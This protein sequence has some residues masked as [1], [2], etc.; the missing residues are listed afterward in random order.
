[1]P[2]TPHHDEQLPAADTRPGT[3][4]LG[5]L[6]FSLRGLLKLTTGVA[7]FFSL[8]A[9]SG[10]SFGTFLLGLYVYCVWLLP[11]TIWVAMKCWPRA[12][13]KWRKW[14]GVT[15]GAALVIPPVVAQLTLEGRAM[16]AVSGLLGLL[17]IWGIEVPVLIFFVHILPSG[18]RALRWHGDLWRFEDD[19]PLKNADDADR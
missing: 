8:V 19:G 1:M 7:V 4:S 6:Q 14:V 5:P 12:H 3:G 11:V 10:V 17:F 18:F 15:V 16:D 13:A 9:V 2:S